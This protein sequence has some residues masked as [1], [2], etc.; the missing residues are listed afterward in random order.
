MT[1]TDNSPMPLGKKFKG[2]PMANV[3]DYHLK[4]WYN[5]LTEKISNKKP[6]YQNERDVLGYIKE[7]LPES[8]D[9]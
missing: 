6:L 9:W 4:W 8:K 7:Y 5:E 3:P 2:V 1:L